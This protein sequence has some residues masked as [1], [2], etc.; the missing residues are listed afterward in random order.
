HSESR[1]CTSASASVRGN[2]SERLQER[3]RIEE[4]DPLHGLPVPEEETVDGGHPERLPA[5]V[6][7]QGE[8]EEHGVPGR[9]PPLE[10]GAEVRHELEEIPERLLAGLEPDGG[11]QP[12]RLQA[13]IRMEERAE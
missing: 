10:L 8:L 3:A 11:R 6:R 7:P 1:R 9:A 4:R 13:P 5:D 12:R 2:R